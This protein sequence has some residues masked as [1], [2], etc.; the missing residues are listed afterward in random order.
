[1]PPHEFIRELLQLNNIEE[2]PTRPN[3]SCSDKEIEN[4]LQTFHLEA[5]IELPETMYLASN[6]KLMERKLR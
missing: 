5:E 4:W 6:K 2:T 1:M 3:Y